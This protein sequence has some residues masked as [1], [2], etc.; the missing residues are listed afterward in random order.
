[1]N[2]TEVTKGRPKTRSV[3][4]EVIKSNETQKKISWRKAGTIQYKEENLI[5]QYSTPGFSLPGCHPSLVCVNLVD[6]VI[7]KILKSVDVAEIF[8]LDLK[9]EVI[10]DNRH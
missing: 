2:G 7:I 10:F 6:N 4:E 5:A 1:M 9:P 3:E 8:I